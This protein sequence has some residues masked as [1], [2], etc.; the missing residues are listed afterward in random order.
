MGASCCRP[1]T[2]PRTL[3]SHQP[4]HAN[5]QMHFCLNY[6][7]LLKLWMKSKLFNKLSNIPSKPN[8]TFFFFSN[9]V[10]AKVWVSLAS[11]HF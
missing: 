11:G 9:L 2:P 7:D 4:D 10:L 6:G 1:R 3:F 5:I 8:W